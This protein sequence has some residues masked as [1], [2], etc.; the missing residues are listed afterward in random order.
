MESFDTA[1][2]SA[3]QGS[4][5][6]V[7]PAAAAFLELIGQ[8]VGFMA[9]GRGFDEQ[10]VARLRLATDEACANALEHGRLGQAGNEMP[11]RVVCETT[12]DGL[13]IRV[14]DRGRAFDPGAITPPQID[15][16]LEKR[17]IGGL[18]IYLMRRIV[19][20]VEVVSTEDGKELVLTKRLPADK[21]VIDDD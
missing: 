12:D 21:A 8:F 6:L 2:A 7:V 10:T 14:R 20:H 1:P 3:V 9:R 15:A 4:A 16:P 18:G 11:L 5:E 17:R 13:R 19:D